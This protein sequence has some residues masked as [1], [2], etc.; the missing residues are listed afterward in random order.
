MKIIKRNG[1]IYDLDVDKI[2]T[3]IL[4][5]AND[6]NVLLTAS[7]VKLLVNKV[8]SIIN[9]IHKDDKLRITSA[10]ELRGIVYYVLVNQGFKNVA[11]AYMDNGFRK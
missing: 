1:S 7:D 6:I 5:S 11:N 2:K 10:Y 9:N 8:L 3:S 4:N